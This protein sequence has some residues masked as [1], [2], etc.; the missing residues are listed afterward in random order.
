MKAVPTTLVGYLKEKSGWDCWA[1]TDRDLA[2]GITCLRL[3]EMT[4][5]SFRLQ[6]TLGRL[7]SFVH[8]LLLIHSTDTIKHFLCVRPCDRYIE[9]IH[10]VYRV[11]KK[12]QA[13]P[14]LKMF[15]V[16]TLLT[17]EDV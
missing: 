2:S 11:R 10:W 13:S 17:L 16:Q 7:L 3:D 8:Y 4:L 14:A 5:G 1:R 9:Y 6:T 15:I 12:T